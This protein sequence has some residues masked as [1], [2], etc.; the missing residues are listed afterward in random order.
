MSDVTLLGL[1]LSGG[2]QKVMKHKANSSVTLPAAELQL[3]KTLKRR[4]RFRSNVDVV[5]RGLKLFEQT[6]SR[7]A[8]KAAYRH[9]SLATREVAV[10]EMEDLD[11]L[12]G[13][14]L[15]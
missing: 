14:G 6:T 15:D 12:A 13:E 1:P 4:L 9:A 5:R 7:E 10:R 2:D 11:H 8:F 3:V